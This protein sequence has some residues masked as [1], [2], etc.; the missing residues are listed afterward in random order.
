MDTFSKYI[1][2]MGQGKDANSDKIPGNILYIEISEEVLKELRDCSE[3]LCIVRKTDYKNIASCN[4]IWQSYDDFMGKTVLSW[5]DEYWLF[6]TTAFGVGE[7]IS[8]FTSCFPAPI[9]IGQQSR[10]DEVGHLETPES[11]Q[12]TDV[13]GEK[14]IT[15]INDYKDS[16]IYPG[17]LELYYDLKHKAVYGPVSLISCPIRKESLTLLPTNVVYVG[18]AQNMKNGDII[19][20]P[21]DTFFEVKLTEGKN[22]IKYDNDGWKKINDIM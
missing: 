20:N 2:M 12:G 8:Y 4:I 19:E 9:D 6:A 21:P 13:S 7:N 18:F 10:L 15:I 22:I 1:D 17:L 5:E 3:R 14:G 16:P 11:Y